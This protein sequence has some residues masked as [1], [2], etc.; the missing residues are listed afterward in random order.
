MH[1]SIPELKQNKDEVFPREWILEA[2]N[3]ANIEIY[4]LGKLKEDFLK[5]KI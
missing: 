2:E 3:L 4:L 1:N 5:Q